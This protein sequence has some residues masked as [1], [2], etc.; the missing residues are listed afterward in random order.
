[1]TYF[2]PVLLVLKNTVPIEVPRWMLS[3]VQLGLP[4]LVLLGQTLSKREP[5]SSDFAGALYGTADMPYL[6]RFYNLGI[7]ATSTLHIVIASRV[8][9]YVPDVAAIKEMVVSSEGLQLVCLIAAILT[10][11]V[12]TIWDL[13]RTNVLQTPVFFVVAAVFLGDICFG[14]A[15]SLIGLWKWREGALERSRGRN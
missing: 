6:S 8:F 3:L 1:M 9:P 7:L 2:V 15:A 5:P 11:S 14:P 10:W 13:R 12:F 4:I